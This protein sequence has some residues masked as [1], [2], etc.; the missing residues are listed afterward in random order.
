MTRLAAAA[1]EVVVVV[2]GDLASDHTEVGSSE[3]IAHNAHFPVV[4]V[5]ALAAVAMVV[6]AVAALEVHPW[7]PIDFA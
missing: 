6:V 5:P 3:G 1:A 4:V 7:D 2:V